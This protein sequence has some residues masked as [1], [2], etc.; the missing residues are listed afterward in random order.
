MSKK[1]KMTES[2]WKGRVL[3]VMKN[4]VCYNVPIAQTGGS[5]ANGTN[6]RN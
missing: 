5:K 2:L 1:E 6:W 4:W 3:V